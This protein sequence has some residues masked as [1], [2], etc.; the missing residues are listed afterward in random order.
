MQSGIV[1]GYF[2]DWTHFKMQTDIQIE[3]NDDN[4]EW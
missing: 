3:N 2:C 1:G 4:Y